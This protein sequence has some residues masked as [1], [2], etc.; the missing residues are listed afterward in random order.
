MSTAFFERDRQHPGEVAVGDEIEVELTE[1]DAC[2]V[3][4]RLSPRAETEPDQPEQSD[5]AADAAGQAADADPA[6]SGGREAPP[7]AER[8]RRRIAVTAGEARCP[9]AA[10]GTGRAAT[11]LK[12][13][14]AR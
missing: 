9:G 7:V 2:R 1:R 5:T 12:T 4:G 8:A 13:S 6:P 3:R 11:G 14:R 10:G